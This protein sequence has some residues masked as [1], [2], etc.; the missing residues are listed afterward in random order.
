V[1]NF[2]IT[3]EN[4]IAE[5]GS[6]CV[7][8]DPSESELNNWGLEDS[9][10]GAKEYSLRCI[11]AVDGRIGII[12]PQVAFFERFGS[13]GFIALEE[14]LQAARDLDLF[15]IAD[16]KR[17]DIGST[18]LGYSQ[19]WFGD[20]SP[21]RVNAL[22][23]SPYLGADSTAEMLEHARDVAGGIFLLAATS[24][25]D[26]GQLQRAV[27]DGQTVAARVLAQ[28]QANGLG[29]CGVVIG[30]T[31]DF[32]SF[33]LGAVT[34][35]DVGVPILAPGFGAQGAQLSELKKLF[36]ESSHRVIPNLSRALT[37]AGPNA[38]AGLI[39]KARLE[40]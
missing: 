27:V 30:A 17:S 4:K 38:M 34:K 12:K 36:G 7:G 14:V 32:D 18:M 33:G 3:L 20:D 28:A 35:T 31:Q 23:V 21:L 10:H 2:A 37:G 22:T 25:K 29:D 19:A 16:A 39:D 15:V 11:D 26:A 9:A 8:I 5:F 6:L 40:L 24:N 13:S 1:N